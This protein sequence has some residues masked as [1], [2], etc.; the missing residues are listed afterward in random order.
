MHMEKGQAYYAQGNYDKAKVELRNVLQIDP[1]SP[2]AYYMVGLIDEE[3]QDWRGAFSSYVKTVELKP[4]HIEAKVKLGRL[5]LLSGKLPEAEEIMNEVLAKRPGH[6]GG[7]FLKA[8]VLVRTGDVA[9]AIQEASEVVA[10]DPAQTD[11]TTLLAGLYARQGDDLRAEQVLEKGVQATPKNISLRMDLAAVAAKRNELEKAEKAYLEVV[12]LE[13]QTLRHR[14]VLANFYTVSNQLDK[15]EKAL[16]DAVQADPDDQQ[17]YLL[18][19]DFLA[20]K[21]SAEQAEK[22]LMSAI[23]AQPKVYPLRFSLARLY[24][25]TG[26][27]QRAEQ[28]YRNIID[29]AKARPEAVKAKALLAR[30]KLSSGD[31]AE[32]EKLIAE[33]LA[34]NPRDSDALQL[35]AQMSLSKRD[36]KQSISDLRA[37]VRDHPDSIEVISLL[38]SAH[39]M[40]NEPQLAKD[41]FNNAIVRYPN[42]T[43]L[44]VALAAFLSASKDDSGALKE[45]D[46]ALNADPQ[47]A[48][49]YQ[50]K[51][52]IQASRNDW[53]AAEQTLTKLKGALP[54]QPVGYYQ[55]GL[56]YKAQKKYDQALAEFD[57]ALKQEPYAAE[58]LTA[59]VNVLL[60]Q[61]HAD[62][63]IVRINQAIQ[64][65]PDH[66][67]AQLLLANV[68]TRQK[69][70]ADAE[71]ALR[72]A[73]KVNPRVPA[74]YVGLANLYIT[75]GDAKRAVE[76]LQQGFGANPG[77]P[78][79]LSYALAETYQRAGDKGQ[80]IAQY[81]KILKDYP[82]A[83]PAANNLAA[84]LSE[85][86]GNKSNLDRAL[87]LAKRFE[88]A[89][90]PSLVDTL[91]WVY[92]QLGDNEHA[93]P[94]L[95]KAV[96]MAPNVPAFQYHLGMALYKQGDIKSAKTHLQLA[97]DAKAEFPG[98]AEAN[99]ILAKK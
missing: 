12:A 8:G 37:V 24:E 1:K 66:L 42:N 71:A 68:Y 85:E 46:T 63:A 34:E 5:Y 98:L 39:R 97:V 49:A 13:P 17:R 22:E 96:T 56:L 94:L 84:L 92:F 44:R 73:I 30:A 89:S 86:K 74:S 60:E 28:T 29:V 26:K 9:G 14:A 59:I 70:Y 48:R 7:R 50:A 69:K 75:R 36:A 57:L 11:A 3:Q 25:A 19:V 2:E 33:V 67:V 27:P 35:R 4:D 38:A 51:A 47:N 83:D 65:S 61:G 10:A 88:N 55:L 87:A 81:E 99:D 53:R 45:L 16:R 64:A 58:P 40:N 52:D 23:Q 15:A 72:K 41:V 93:L 6:P 95:Q 32:A 77:E 80:A 54:S 21:R 90:N 31:L 43:D 76:A 78:L 91:G 82:G 79:L 20:Q 18:L 62:K